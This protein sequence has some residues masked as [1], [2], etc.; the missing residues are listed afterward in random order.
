[1]W[2]RGKGVDERVPFDSD[3]VVGTWS[4]EEGRGVR[5]RSG[6]SHDVASMICLASP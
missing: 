4:K 5:V 1:M 2:G 6:A 3:V